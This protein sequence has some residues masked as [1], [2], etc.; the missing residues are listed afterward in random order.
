MSTSDPQPINVGFHVGNVVQFLSHLYGNGFAVLR[1]AVQNAIDEG[2]VKILLI[3][4][5]IRQS[6]EIYDNGGGA[7][8]DEIT[9]KFESIGLS[10]KDKD[11]IGSKGIGN[12]AGLAIAERWQFITRKNGP[13]YRF[14]F[15][16]SELEKSKNVHVY[17]ELLPIKEIRGG[18]FSPTSLLKLHGVADISLKQLRDQETIE[19]TLR[20]AFN[21]KLR[22]RNIELRVSY[23]DA[24]NKRHDFHVK[25]IAYR[26]AK[27]ESV[28]IDTPYGYIEF[29][30]FHSPNPLEKPTVLVQHQGTYFMPLSNFFKMKILP[31][32]IEYLFNR[33]YFEGEIKLGFCTINGDRSAFE[34]NKEFSAFVDAVTSFAEDVLKPL[35]ERFEQTDR[36]E[37]LKRIAEGVLKRMKDF[38]SR[39]PD[40]VPP[41][42]R[43]LI[44][45]S[46]TGK[47]VENKDTSSVFT[48]LSK[49]KKREPLPP[50]ALKKQKGESEEKRK[51]AAGNG[52][53][54]EKRRIIEA[55]EGLGIQFVHPDPEIDGF[56]WHSRTSSEGVIQINI[57]NNEF[58]EAEKRGQTVLGRYFTTLLH[59]EMTC[60]SLSPHESDVFNAGF[61]LMLEQFYMASI[62]E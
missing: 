45:K 38:L 10:L 56:K 39:R 21:T 14:T 9:K 3:I 34:H 53:G 17:P 5:C 33:G 16:R 61:E 19:K 32:S 6:I 1:E 12:L 31:Q 47:G 58:L 15:D 59:K 28:Q 35:T 25:P 52:N 13:F 8:V 27:M 60:A 54:K 36:E 37:R 50:D 48:R 62:Q 44:S 49:K 18:H 2:A 30:M 24:K 41:Q 4:D 7:N 43:S 22:S 40:L 11:K 46:A 57:A 51:R 26:G 20:E 29:A 55:V 42:F 23:R